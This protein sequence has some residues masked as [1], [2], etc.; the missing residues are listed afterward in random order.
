MTI[1]SW[2]P[3]VPSLRDEDKPSST[4]AMFFARSARAVATRKSSERLR[5]VA[6]PD[7]S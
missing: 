5:T 3:A 2:L 1:A 7:A 6:L 4:K